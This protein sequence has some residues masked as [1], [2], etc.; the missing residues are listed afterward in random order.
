MA[1]AVGSIAVGAFFMALEIAG[2]RW[3]EWAV[4]VGLLRI[5]DEGK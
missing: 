5:Q 3:A 4:S 1:L 2:L